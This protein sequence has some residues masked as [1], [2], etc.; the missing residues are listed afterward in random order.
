MAKENSLVKNA[1]VLMIASIV[2]R[3]IG[4]MYR[5]PLGEIVGSVG[6]GYYGFASNLYTTLLLI[7]S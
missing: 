2:S 6:M 7:S 4:L 5:R 3:I 1:S